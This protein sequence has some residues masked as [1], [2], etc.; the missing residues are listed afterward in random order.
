M[1]CTKKKVSFVK[2][3]FHHP[4]VSPTIFPIF[5]V[6][7]GC[8]SFGFSLTW[9]IVPYEKHGM[10]ART[11]IPSKTDSS[12]APTNSLCELLG[13]EG[14]KVHR[15]F[16]GAC[17]GSTPPPPPEKEKKYQQSRQKKVLGWRKKTNNKNIGFF[18]KGP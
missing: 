15:N 10:I 4:T 6:F 9:S 14:W 17:H 12:N 1:I 8:E 3:C 18:P 16:N 7:R 2:I 5:C 13:V 11:K